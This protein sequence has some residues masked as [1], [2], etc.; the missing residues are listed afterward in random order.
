MRK[1]VPAVLLA[2]VAIALA[3]CGGGGGKTAATDQSTVDSAQVP[4]DR[5]FIDAMVPHHQSAIEMAREA[6][7]AG[8]AEPDLLE[9]ANNI[10][11]TQQAEIDQMLDWRSEWFG[12]STRDAEETA[13]EALGLTASEAGMEHHGMDLSTADDVDQTFA[14]MMVAHHEG[15][16]RMAQLANH[17]AGHDEIKTLA[18]QIIAAQRREIDVMEKHAGGM[19][20]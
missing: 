17:R 11:A 10:I 7:Q 20:E 3:G 6:K 5:A 13:L 12:S 16:I 19:H 4:F 18:G 14:E 2:V 1:L 15:A 9:I 8:L